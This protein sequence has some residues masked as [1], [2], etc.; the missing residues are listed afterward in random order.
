MHIQIRCFQ[1]RFLLSAE[2]HLVLQQTPHLAESIWNE[3]RGKSISVVLI[4]KMLRQPLKVI[5]VFGEVSR[6][7]RL[8]NF[9]D[10][11]PALL[12]DRI[13]PCKSHHRAYTAF[14]KNG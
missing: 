11:A 6:N 7:V 13:L 5:H 3:A 12:C 1:Q 2:I 14:R 4:A 8:E 9:E 10:T